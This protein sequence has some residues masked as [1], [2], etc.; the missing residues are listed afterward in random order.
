MDI[1][2]AIIVTPSLAIIFVLLWQTRKQKRVEN[3]RRRRI[4]NRYRD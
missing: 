2:A 1:W 3:E 4:L